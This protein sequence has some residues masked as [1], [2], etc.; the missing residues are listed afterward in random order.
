MKLTNPRLAV[1][2]SLH[3]VV[4]G[5]LIPAAAQ[6]VAPRAEMRPLASSVGA[7]MAADNRKSIGGDASVPSINAPVLNPIS[8]DARNQS[9]SI[10]ERRGAIEQMLQSH[11]FSFGHRQR[12]LA[13]KDAA[14]STGVDLDRVKLRV[15]RD[16]V[17][18]K[19]QFTFN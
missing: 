17:V 14:K 5:W 11:E 9:L 16:S 6:D 3:V 2:V 1:A 19:A 8:P 18:I 12:S 15:S 4:V 7:M 13:S 10:T